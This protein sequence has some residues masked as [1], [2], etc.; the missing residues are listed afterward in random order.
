MDEPVCILATGQ[1][2]PESIFSLKDFIELQ[3]SAKDFA[4]SKLDANDH[5]QGQRIADIK[6]NFD[7]VKRCAENSAI[8]KRHG[9][10]PEDGKRLQDFYEKYDYNPP[11]TLRAKYWRKYCPEL[12]MNAVQK[13][14]KEWGGDKNRITHVVSHSTTGWDVPGLS[15]HVMYNLELPTSARAVP[16]NFVGCQ[17]GTSVMFVAATI[18]KQDPN[19]VVLALAAEIQSPLGRMYN[20]DISLEKSIYMPNVLFGDA[21]GAAVIARPSTRGKS[22][23]FPAFE[24]LDMGAHYIPDTRHVL[25]IAVSEEYGL[26][27]ENSIKKEL[28]VKLNATLAKDFRKWQKSVLGD[29]IHPDECA[30]AVHPGG[31]KLLNNFESLIT[32]HGVRGADKELQFSYKNLREYGNLASAAII[33][34]LGDVCRN[35]RKDSIFFMAMGPGVCLEYGG[36][37]RY[38]AGS[39]A[40]RSNRATTGNGSDLTPLLLA[41]IVL[42]IGFILGGYTVNDLKNFL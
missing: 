4:I 9:I 16:V 7:W 39:K 3:S 20:D 21:A 6:A 30:Y 14:V 33:F 2:V 38:K 13:A 25:T 28:P 42:L 34:I 41:I 22:C 24:Y 32:D 36:M 27:Y 35:T 11:Y 18:A 23:A 15:H 8:E 40:A 26:Y 12:A 37:R 31:K 10:I 19:A 17:G 29:K 1:S 5:D